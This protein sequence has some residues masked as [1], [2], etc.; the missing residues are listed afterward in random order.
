CSFRNA[1]TFK[2]LN[3]RWNKLKGWRPHGSDTD[4]PAIDR[5]AQRRSIARVPS[6]HCLRRLLT[7][8][9]GRTVHDHRERARG[10]RVRGARTRDHDFETHRLPWWDADVDR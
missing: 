7:D 1:R 10:A 9:Q 8:A 3:C 5:E 6:D 2:E 4:P